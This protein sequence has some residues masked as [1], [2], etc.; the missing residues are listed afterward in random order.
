MG[1]PA[2]FTYADRNNLEDTETGDAQGKKENHCRS[3]VFKT[4]EEIGPSKWEERLAFGTVYIN[5]S[6]NGT[7]F[8]LF[9]FPS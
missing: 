3:E 5:Y 9:F 6:E 2:S 7:R 1:D 4:G 8:V